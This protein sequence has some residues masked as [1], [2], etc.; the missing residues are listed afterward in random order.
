[1]TP[2]FETQ[3]DGRVLTLRFTED[4]VKTFDLV[5]ALGTA[6]PSEIHVYCRA[7]TRIN[8]IGA[9]CWIN[10]FNQIRARGTNLHFFECPPP[11][12]EQVSVISNFLC[13]GVAES[14]LLPYAC[15]ACGNQFQISEEVVSLKKNGL[16]ATGAPCPRCGK[17][18]R[19]DDIEDEYLAFLK[20]D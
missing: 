2:P 17:S 8:S 5:T 14:L 4:L 10:G 13:G 11:I 12:V 16:K 9:K 18:A 15:A 1:M 7:I 19:F 6:L 3:A 20:K